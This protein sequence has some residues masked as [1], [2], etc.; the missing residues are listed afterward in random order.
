MYDV[1]TKEVSD[2]YFEMTGYRCRADQA[3]EIIELYWNR[4]NTLEEAIE[5]YAKAQG[6]FDE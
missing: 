2:I 3:D 6:D 4:F 1:T 5:W